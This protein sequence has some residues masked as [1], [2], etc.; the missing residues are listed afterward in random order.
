M[1]ARR[2]LFCLFAAVF[3]VAACASAGRASEPQVIVFSNSGH[4]PVS[5]VDLDSSDGT[6]IHIERIS[7]GGEIT[8]LEES[9]LPEYVTLRWKSGGASPSFK[10]S[11]RAAVP[12][13]V[14]RRGFLFQISDE[15]VSVSASEDGGSFSKSVRIYP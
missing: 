11:I 4:G 14:R 12:P 6:T 9:S 2:V 10:I 13:R 3:L 7:P 15:T 1:G 8:R 5:D